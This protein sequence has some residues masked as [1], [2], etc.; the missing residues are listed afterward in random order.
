MGILSLHLPMMLQQISKNTFAR[1]HLVILIGLTV[2][3]VLLVTF[4]Q[5]SI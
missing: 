3:L 1:M 2:Q 5:D 4:I